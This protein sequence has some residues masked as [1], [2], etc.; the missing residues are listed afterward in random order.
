MEKY[1]LLAVTSRYKEMDGTVE[2]RSTREFNSKLFNEIQKIRENI[3][4][5]CLFSEDCE[6]RGIKA[7]SVPR[8]ILAGMQKEGCVIQPES[9]I[10]KNPS[11]R[12]GPHLLFE[13][14]GINEAST[15]T[16]ICRSHD[17]AFKEID[18]PDLD[19]CNQR[20]LDLLMYR[21]T[22]RELWV[23]TRTLE[24]QLKV[25]EVR[26][27]RLSID[28]EIKI[29][30]AVDLAARLKGKLEETRTS[31]SESILR[32]SHIV[33]FIKTEIPIIGSASAGSSSDVVADRATREIATLDETRRYMGREPNTSWTFTIIPRQNDHIVVA[34]YIEGSIARDFFDHIRHANGAELQQAVSAELL[35]FC[36]NWFINPVVWEKYG[37][38]RQRAISEV[39]DN[40]GGLLSGRYRWENKTENEKWYEFLGI[41]NR[42][43]INMFSY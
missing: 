30:A 34:S 39:Y 15:G 28:P 21:A 10:F 12:I 13:P 37:N 14:I 29:R 27:F 38:K 2:E 40:I 25:R 3:P 24:S 8:N 41:N 11:G 23:Q 7:H 36:E 4:R 9:K 18:H 32:T 43:Q 31:E 22:L 17:E 19:I 42:Q 20:T 16:F 1:I 33:R 26:P 35:M 5:K 6:S